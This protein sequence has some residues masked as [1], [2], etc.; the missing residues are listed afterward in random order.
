MKNPGRNDERSEVIVQTGFG[1]HEG[2]SDAQN[3]SLQPW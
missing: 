2:Y 3:Q 1:W